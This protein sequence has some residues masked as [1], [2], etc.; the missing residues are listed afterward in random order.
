[1]SFCPSHYHCQVSFTRLSLLQIFSLYVFLTNTLTVFLTP[2]LCLS[3]SVSLSYRSF[4]SMFFLTNTLTV[5]LTPPLCL[6]LSV[7]LSVCLSPLQI[8]SLYV[9]LTN[10]LTVFLTPPLCLS[11]SVSLSPSL[12]LSL[13]DLF[14][15]R[16]LFLAYSVCIRQRQSYCG[17]TRK[18]KKRRK[19]KN[20]DNPCPETS[21]P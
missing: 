3:L 13:T 2:P 21:S 20:T 11:L 9:F 1:M 14:L 18:R 4:L 12:S 6:S 10:T 5:F 8:F 15:P 7:S 16:S 17:M 19:M